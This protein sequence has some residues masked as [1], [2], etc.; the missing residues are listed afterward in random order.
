MDLALSYQ[1]LMAFARERLAPA[2]PPVFKDRRL[3]SLFGTG[4]LPVGVALCSPADFPLPPHVLQLRDLV[5]GVGNAYADFDHFPDVSAMRL[6]AYVL[7]AY[8]GVDGQVSSEVD[9]LF[10]AGVL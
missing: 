2:L 1:R 3:A 4:A 6:M 10:K 5:Y 8:L 7:A 9:C